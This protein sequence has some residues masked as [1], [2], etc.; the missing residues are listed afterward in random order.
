M[1]ITELLTDYMK[2]TEKS[3]QH[4]QNAKNFLPGGVSGSG[5]F[6]KPYPIYIKSASG[7]EIVDF[8]DN[9]YIDLV[10][11]NGVSIL[12]HGNEIVRKSVLQAIDNPPFVFLAHKRELL[13]A[14][15]INN[16][17][18]SMEMIRFANSGSEAVHMCIRAA[19]AY[20]GKEKIAKFE[21]HFNGGADLL[22]VSGA[23]VDGTPRNPLPIIDGAGIPKSNLENILILPF[24]DVENAVALIKENAKD[25]AAVILEPIT[26]FMLCCVPSDNGFLE[27]IREVTSENGIILIFDE[28]VTGFRIALGGAAEYFGV[29]PD[30][31]TMGKAIS[32]GY[33]LCVYGG[34]RE[35]MDNVVTPTKEPSDLNE[36][37]FQSGT[38]TGHPVSLA[39]GLSVLQEIE[40]GDVIP[41]INDLG[42]YLRT[43][44]LE[45]SK[46][47]S[48]PV[49]ITGAGSMFHI[50]F[51]DQP[52]KSKRDALKANAKKG[53]EFSLRLLLDGVYFPPSH[54]ALLSVAHGKKE[55]DYLLS[56]IEKAFAQMGDLL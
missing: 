46:R 7:C 35:I 28:I 33:P 31:H 55:I 48:C 14:Q 56:A 17:V 15:K 26:G 52:V 50:F 34:K 53:M 25:L 20:S 3:H 12:G 51:T 27:A 5:K 47:A 2:K 21:G 4:Y 40:K 24:N 42:D 18:E 8:D 23:R 29:R 6:L 32:G 16:H 37:I 11:G 39:A 13:L 45:I 43:N 36:K 41:Y 22:L 30:M 44:I 9:S 38:F 54:P 1:A 49:Q 19:M 10:M